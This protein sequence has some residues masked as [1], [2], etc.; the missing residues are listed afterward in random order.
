MILHGILRQK[1]LWSQCQKE[2]AW[3]LPKIRTRSFI[4]T[5]GYEP[6]HNFD[7][8]KLYTWHQ[9][10]SLL[11]YTKGNQIMSLH[12]IFLEKYQSIRKK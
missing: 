11:G 5:S 9:G 2:M 1:I 8:K 10:H 6:M 3:E 4:R 12:G 7:A